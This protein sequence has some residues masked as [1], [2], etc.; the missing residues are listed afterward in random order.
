MMDH[1]I[2]ALFENPPL[3]LESHTIRK[4][5]KTL[6]SKVLEGSPLPS[7]ASLRHTYRFS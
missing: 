5:L 2:V 4:I 3:I 7:P 1:A 6:R